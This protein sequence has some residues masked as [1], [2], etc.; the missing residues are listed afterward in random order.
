MGLKMQ[1]FYTPRTPINKASKV[2]Q[3]ARPMIHLHAK[4][5]EEVT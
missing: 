4:E 2:W 5:E 3:T 1:A